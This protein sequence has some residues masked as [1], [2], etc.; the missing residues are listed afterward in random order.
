VI[1]IELLDA[2]QILFT[3]S[4]D[5]GKSLKAILWETIMQL[6]DQAGLAYS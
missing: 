5:H 4:P 6:G 2:P 1:S 3:P